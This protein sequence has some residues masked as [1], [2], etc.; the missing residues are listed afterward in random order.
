MDG[1]IYQI[2]CSSWAGKVTEI[3]RERLRD[4]HVRKPERPTEHN[5]LYRCKHILHYSTLY[6]LSPEYQFYEKIPQIPL[7]RKWSLKVGFAIDIKQLK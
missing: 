1:G 6:I 4:L 2:G 7:S 3:V 5:P